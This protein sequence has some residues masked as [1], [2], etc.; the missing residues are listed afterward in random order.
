MESHQLPELE[1][2]AQNT[3]IARAG[4]T[5]TLRGKRYSVVD[6]NHP[7]NPKGT[8]FSAYRDYGRFRRLRQGGDRVGAVVDPEVSLPHRRGL[9]AGADVIQKC[10]DEFAGVKSPTTVPKTTVR[11]ADRWTA[12]SWD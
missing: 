4:K 12:E 6:L 2:V 11:P 3:S 10:W 1:P 9:D 7:D 8:K 5:Y